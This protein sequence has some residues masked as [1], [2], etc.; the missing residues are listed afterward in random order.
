MQLLGE[1]KKLR[2]PI[3]PRLPKTFIIEEESIVAEKDHKSLS[4]SQNARVGRANPRTEA[5]RSQY[6]ASS[7][8]SFFSE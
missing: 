1:M 3:M 7:S 2:N 8:V 5:W 6:D 4:E